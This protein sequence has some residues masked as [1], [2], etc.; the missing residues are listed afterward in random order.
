MEN[1]ENQ[2]EWIRMDVASRS[3]GSD[4][5]VE[6][7]VTVRN[8]QSSKRRFRITVSSE[9]NQVDR[10][11]EWSL[12]IQDQ[13]TK[14][15]SLSPIDNKPVSEEFDIDGKKERKLVLV[16]TTPKGGYL[17][18][19][20]SF[21]V[22]VESDDG[23]HH[24]QKEF[25]LTL[26]PV[27]VAI[28]TT[29]GNEF[30]VSRDLER[31]SEKDK[32]ERLER[33]EKATNE[34]FAIMAPHEV[35]G[36]VFVETMHPDRVSFIAKGIKGYK[37]MVEGDIKLEEIEHYLTPKP[38]VTGLELGAFVELI[39]GPF[40]GEKAKIM[41]IDSGKEEVTVQLVESMVPI[42]VTVRAEAIRMLDNK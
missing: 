38:A 15:F 4:R 13:K 14:T 1:A 23:I 3:V 31:R 35:K 26:S 6:V 27:I 36:Y 29:V 37:G 8:I 28:K 39:D 17:G 40:K 41:S 10:L 18:D 21:V 12:A 9:F 33:D 32:Q 19:R 2:F 42:P 22:T 20:A 7:P 16:F 11:V 30:P 24:L 5:P 25:T 34:V